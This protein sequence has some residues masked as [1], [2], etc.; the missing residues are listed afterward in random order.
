MPDVS[1]SYNKRIDLFAEKPNTLLPNVTNCST[2]SHLSALCNIWMAPYFY[3]TF[4][5]CM[6]SINKH[7]YAMIFYYTAFLESFMVT[8]V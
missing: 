2:P 6:S 5:N 7:N 4:K 1:T 8:S 3:Q